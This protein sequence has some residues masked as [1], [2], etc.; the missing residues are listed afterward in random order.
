MPTSSR[1][2]RLLLVGLLALVAAT[3]LWML[4]GVLRGAISLWQALRELPTWAQA[5]VCVVVVAVVIGLAFVA[6]RIMH[7]RP[8]KPAP[9]AAPTRAQV[10]Q[11]VARLQ[12]QRTDTAN[13]QAELEELDR[14]AR[15]E[16]LYVAVFG[17]ISAG[18]SSLIRALVP[19]ASAGTDVLGGTTR[20][21]EHYR[22]A[23]GASA[24]VFAD[25]PGTHEA[26]GAAREQLA[27]DEALRAHVVLYVCAGDL[28]REQ[29]T[30]LRWLR[31]FGKPLLLVL[32]KADQFRAGERDALERTLR[33][34]YARRHR[35]PARRERWRQRKL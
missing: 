1:P 19:D 10:D 30:E 34:R 9:V 12:G 20:S 29:D 5:G 22:G 33:E 18:K 2:L 4:F 25:V 6:W 23:L 31:G 13:L 16:E 32:N 27:R 26:S 8:R 7:P 15:S 11:R 21:V 14:R 24:L 3:L 28:T 17:E 35:C